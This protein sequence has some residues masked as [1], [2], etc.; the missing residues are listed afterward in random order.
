MDAYALALSWLAS[1]ELTER[2]VRERLVRRGVEASAIDEA[3]RRLRATGALDDRRAAGAHART[4]VRL[5][6]RGPIR[7]GRDL[8]A[9][10]ISASLARE[11]IADALEE[12]PE[13]ALIERALDR[14][15]PRTGDM[16]QPALGRVYRALLRQGFAP[17]KV[18]AAL[19]R[20]A[21]AID[22]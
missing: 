16:S 4:A 12:T 13:E 7:L 18:M 14:R 15:W 1:R 8:E 3:V 5:K 11:A 19:R 17:D 20:R 6:G 2:Q 10:G 21:R 9:L 22:E